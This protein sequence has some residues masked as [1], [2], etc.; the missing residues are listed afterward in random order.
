MQH[1]H[2]ATFRAELA[3]AI[4]PRTVLLVVGVLLVQLA[5][6]ASYVGAFHDPQPHDVSVGV[7]APTRDAAVRVVSQLEGID[8]H[9]LAALA[10][11]DRQAAVRQIRDADLAGAVVI[12]PRGTRD[13]LL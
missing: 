2:R 7:V 4:A 10:V 12:A 8:G 11:A 1:S 5:F 9:P 6:V 3:D 13:E